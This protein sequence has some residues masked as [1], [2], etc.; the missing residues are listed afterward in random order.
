MREKFRYV[1]TNLLL[2]VDKSP[3][4]M[5]EITSAL[6]NSDVILSANIQDLSGFY[7]DEEKVDKRKLTSEELSDF[8]D[9]I[10]S[11]IYHSILAK[12]NMKMVIYIKIKKLIYIGIIGKQIFKKYHYSVIQDNNKVTKIQE[13]FFNSTKDK[14]VEHFIEDVGQFKFIEDV[15]QFKFNSCLWSLFYTY[16]CYKV[17]IT[18]C[19]SKC[20]PM[21]Y[22]IID[23]TD[24]NSFYSIINDVTFETLLLQTQL[25]DERNYTLK[26]ALS[27]INKKDGLISFLY[28]HFPPESLESK[29][30]IIETLKEL[31]IE[32]D[33][34]I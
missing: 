26:T 31:D 1:G 34:E 20:I 14:E 8:A 5:K 24:P 4:T 6:K 3:L 18:F 25:N 11:S 27:D 19:E 29:I 28:N 32:I 10:T 30:K 22:S 33:K 23:D 17:G 15:G 2:N 7:V 16:G 21:T 12:A 13:A 9:E